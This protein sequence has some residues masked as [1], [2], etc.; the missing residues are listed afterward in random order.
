M[1]A[2]W[3]INW[4]DQ[5]VK[6]LR[7]LDK[8][9]QSKILKYMAERISPSEDPYAFGKPLRHDKYGLWRYRV[10]DTRIICKVEKG[11]LLILILA[12]GHRKR[13]YK[14]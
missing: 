12:V 3:K 6:Q 10:G 5:A 7:K 11:E 2:I 13:I 8:N 14:I 4:S 1:T 9:N